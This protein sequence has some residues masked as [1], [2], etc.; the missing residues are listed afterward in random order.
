MQ[1]ANL[2]PSSPGCSAGLQRR[3]P[4][5]RAQVHAVFGERRVELW[6]IGKQAYHLHV[7]RLYSRVLPEGCSVRA[8]SRRQRVRLLLQKDTKRSWCFLKG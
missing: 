4:V 2:V 3:L 6:A 8:D 5:A 7:P 1:P